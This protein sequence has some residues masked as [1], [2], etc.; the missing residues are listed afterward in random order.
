MFSGEEGM[1]RERSSAERQ[2]AHVVISARAQHA[3]TWFVTGRGSEAET[4][5]AYVEKP[6]L[7]SELPGEARVPARGSG[8]AEEGVAAGGGAAGCRERGHEAGTGR[9]GC[10]SRRFAALRSGFGIR[11]RQL[12]SHHAPP[13]HGLRHYH[14]ED[15]TAGA[16]L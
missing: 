6:R 2:R 5:A 13:E 4:E 9:V 15:T 14:S 11:R 1:R 8:A 10:P 3:L 7:R 12:T 16:R